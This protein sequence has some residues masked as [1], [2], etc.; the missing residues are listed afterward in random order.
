MWFEVLGDVRA[1]TKDGGLVALP[2]G[3]V[4]AVLAALLAH[5]GAPVSADRL[6]DDVWGED[7]PGNPVNTLQTKVS[8][9]RRVL[10]QAEPGARGLVAYLPA[11]YLLQIED[12][13]VDAARFSALVGRARKESEPGVRVA[14]LTDALALWRGPA[15]ADFRDA[16]FTRASVTR[17]EEQ[18]LTAVEDL[19]ELCLDLGEHALV[20]DELADLV[21]ANPLRERLRAAQM[22]A[23]YRAGRQAEALAAYQD[24]RERLADELGLDPGDSVTALHQAIL[25]RD[26]ELVAPAA[27]V[28]SAARPTTNLPARLDAPVGRDA[29]I[30]RV[31]GLLDSSRLVTLVGP[32]GVGK[33]R[34]ALAAASARTART[35][36]ADRADRV[37]RADHVDPTDCGDGDDG[38]ASEAHEAHEAPDPFPD[39]VWLVELASLA[40]GTAALAP[41]VAAAL[42][43]RDDAAHGSALD[44]LADLLRDRRLL[45]LLDNCEHVVD[46]AAELA[47][48][49]LRDAAG[50]RL[51]A[52]SQEPLAVAGEI[53]EAVVPLEEHDAVRLFADRAAASSPGFTLD[54][55]RSA[56][57]AAICRRLDH[58]P[59][60]IELAAARV[61]VL[62]LDELALR[63]D[64]RFRVLAAGRRDA[65]SR[66]RTL[67][68]MIDWSWDPLTAPERAVL[69]RLS[70][71]W[72]GCSLDSAED[73]CADAAPGTGATASAVRRSE[74]VDIVSRLVDRSLLT[75]VTG[76]A[77]TRYRLLESVAAY[78]RE[79]L[80]EAGETAAFTARHR[81]HFTARAER[82][83]PH[84][85]TRDQRAW[86]TRLD[87]DAADLRAALDDAVAAGTREA[88]A[89]ALRLVNALSWYWMLRGRLTEARR[90]LDAVLGAVPETGSDNSARADAIARRAA[91]ALLTGDGAY[92]DATAP[93]ATPRAAWFL[94]FARVGF[95]ET[96]DVETELAP[97]LDAFRTGGDTWG[98]AAAL[99]TRA[100]KAI[101]DGDLTA[102]R[103]DA[104]ESAGLFAELGDRWG[105]LRATEQLGLLAEI[106]GDYAE[107]A[108]LHRD[109]LRV[110][111]EL[112]LWVEASFRL[113]RLGRIALLTGEL[114]QADDFHS[115]AVRLAAEQSHRPAEQFAAT[116]LAIGARRRGD[117][118]RAEELLRPWVAW[119]RRLGVAAGEALVLTLLGLVAEQR[120][121]AEAATSLHLEG[122]TAAARTGD[123]RAVA[124]ALEGLAGARSLAG[125]HERAAALLGTAEALRASVDSP[126]PDA[127]R[128][129][130]D[131]AAAR[132]RHGLGAETYA[133]A[134]DAGRTMT[135]DEHIAALTPGPR[136]ENPAA[137]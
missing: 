72:N 29:A 100:G 22:R 89:D 110:A 7:A 120:G 21:A 17:L 37:G 128:D 69:R 52:T 82:A 42:G 20:A 10:D 116:G 73:V 62:G 108:R 121:D 11:G 81:T 80:D 102:L 58:L 67:R 135:P 71:F 136:P 44:R 61:R 3:K 98:L 75:V 94:A 83:A 27:P 66:Q 50:V 65:P 47:A 41:A 70:V 88:L 105:H 49:L 8:Q 43:L 40:P 59:L 117:H 103:A 86:L 12:D 33:T 76:A 4:R 109:A 60:A 26:P 14:L 35:A 16:E 84:L 54:D 9:L 48:R 5:Q 91:F 68:A 6:I 15:F 13:A 97:V 78:G 30:T 74:V 107:A 39:G 2:E 53:V 112:H 122:Y 99:S 1:R 137:R 115:R 28:A 63:L 57:V 101:Y 23:L 45:L 36:R 55:A 24:L 124:F 118:A 38:K 51:L 133:K 19:A 114:D 64:D 34:L 134:V 123:P 87:D 77:G 130:V 111:E 119:N 32:G 113:A 18:R 90:A 93:G 104:V 79:R 125:D 92:A 25:V 129:D 95:G 132:A 56:T 106:A 131:R 85:H 31:C 126:L 127:E 46:E 96:A